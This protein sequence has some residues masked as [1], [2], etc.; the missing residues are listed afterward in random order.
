MECLQTHE[1][2]DKK[3]CNDQSET[4]LVLL[5]MWPWVHKSLHRKMWRLVYNLPA[6]QKM[7]IKNEWKPFH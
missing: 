4:L 5:H 1:K 2:H 7:K 6:L 3:V